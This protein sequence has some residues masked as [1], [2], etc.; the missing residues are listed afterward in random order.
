[1]NNYLLKVLLTV[2]TVLLNEQV[3]A[4]VIADWELD[5]P[6]DPN[7]NWV[8]NTTPPPELSFSQIGA[9]NS[10]VYN[11][12]STNSQPEAGYVSS[13]H[14]IEVVA[15]GAN[16]RVLKVM[17]DGTNRLAEA[18]Y[19]PAAPYS[20]RAELSWLN[21]RFME[22]EELYYTMSF[23]L[24]DSWTQASSLPYATIITQLKPF[25]T[26]PMVE[27]M[28]RNNGSRNIHLHGK[29]FTAINEDNGYRN[30]GNAVVGEWVHVKMYVKL[31]TSTATSGASAGKVIAWINGVKTNEY[32]GRTLE[33][34]NDSYLKLGQYGQIWDRKKVVYF[35][36]VRLEKMIN[37][38][39]ESW[40]K[41]QI[42]KVGYTFI[43]DHITYEITSVD[44]YEVKVTDYTGTATEV[45]IPSEVNNYTI[46]RIES[47]AFIKEESSPDKLKKVTI[48]GSVTTIGDNA[49]THNELTS[50]EIPNVT[51]IGNNAFENNQLESV[52]IPEGLVIISPAAFKNNKL[53]SIEIPN[54]VETIGNSAF[55]GNDLKSVD[56]PENVGKIEAWA[57]ANNPN[58]NTVLIKATNPPVVENDIFTTTSPNDDRNGQID[59]MVPEGAVSAYN[60]WYGGNNYFKSITE[61]AEVND[62]FTADHITY[63]ITEITPNKQVSATEYD[64]AGGPSVTIPPTV[65]YQGVDYAVTIIG[66]DTFK[67]KQLTEVTIG[68]NVTSIGE[69]A[70]NNNKLT[71]VVIPNSVTN[72]GGQAFNNNRNLA[73]VTVERNDPPTLHA[74]AFQNANRNKIDLV[75]PKSKRQAYLDNGWTGFKS[76]TFGTFTDQDIQYG[77][78]AV[79]PNEVKV[80]DYIGSATA[81]EIP[82]TVTYEGI[83]YTVT[84]IGNGAFSDNPDLVTVKIEATHPLALHENAFA[85][86]SQINLIVPAGTREDYLDNG[87][88]GFRSIMEEGQVLTAGSN[89][90]FKDFTLYPNPARDKVHIDI[91]PG[92]GQALKQVNIYTMA[93]AYL[94]SENGLEI[95]TGRL[96]RGMYLFEIVTKTGDR[97]MR[98]VIIQ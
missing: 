36:N 17:A 95:N 71:N 72:I 79:N 15:D 24:D 62:E 41:D 43:A 54:N 6:G 55:A 11:W 3:G 77:I 70:F 48:P 5:F 68:E 27:L 31:T 51:T 14:K 69:H 23:K 18:L 58:L 89:I 34:S 25:G 28:V 12:F 75:V 30:I 76:I 4:Q 65:Q 78:T 61:V 35:D 74:D 84:A 86:R 98:R 33:L 26:G 29:Y 82:E 53:T 1:M 92:S 73:L 20:N 42:A 63:Q 66:N 59:L 97:S 19:D 57:F 9:D 85:D 50:I 39:L 44:S 49:F 64:M 13:I 45:I 47:R 52:T 32:T 56:I 40:S 60:S 2:T 38:S 21:Y 96:S 81:I 7:R 46:T 16:N 94:Y 8:S 22:G 10:A 80:M 87:W 88:D 90:E 93:G 37:M 91:D 67:E 83:T